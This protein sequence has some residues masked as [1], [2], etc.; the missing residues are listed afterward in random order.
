MHIG[1]TVMMLKQYLDLRLAGAPVWK[2]ILVT[3]VL[4][5]LCL[6][7]VPVGLLTCHYVLAVV[8][9]ILALGIVAEGVLALLH[10]RPP[11]TS[12]DIAALKSPTRTATGS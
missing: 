3:V 12:P 5:A 7:L 4:I 8:G 11:A 10:R 9:A 1:R 6:A 2:R